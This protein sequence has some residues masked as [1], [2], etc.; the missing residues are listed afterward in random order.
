MWKLTLGYKS[1]QLGIANMNTKD[2]TKMTKY[3]QINQ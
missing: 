1:M 2:P 3:N